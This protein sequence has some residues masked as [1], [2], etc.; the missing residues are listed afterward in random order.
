MKPINPEDLGTPRGFSHGMLEPSNGRVLF[1]AGQ[2]AAD[3][4]GHVGNPE[5]VAQFESALAKALLVVTSVGGRVEHVGRMTVY[6]TD[7]VAY[8]CNRKALGEVW[9]RHM[10][11][12]YP[13]MALVQVSALV[14]EE[15]TVEIEVTAILP[16]GHGEASK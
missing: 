16:D 14:D 7:I 15:A 1:V 6:V 11:S 10:G 13:A 2:T 8:R 4:D 9:Q 12:H 5:F 3:A